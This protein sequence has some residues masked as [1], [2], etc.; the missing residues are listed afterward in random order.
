MTD[1]DIARPRRDGH[2]VLWGL[3]A[4]V[5]VAVAVGLILGSGALAVTKALGLSGSDGPSSSSTGQESMYLPEPVP[6]QSASGPLITLAPDPEGTVTAPSE[7]PSDEANQKVI[8]LSAGQTTVG[9]ME[10]IDL[11]GTYPGGEGAIL[12]VQQFRDGGW[13]DFPVTASVGNETF[14]TYIQT[15]NP[16]VN[17]FRM[18]DT[19]TQKASNEVKVTIS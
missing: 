3:V 14:A 6:T 11:T 10:K 1:D 15:R 19:D 9:P 4:L 8:S 7:E 16:G 13:T 18:L 17:R 12:Q 5:S 2:P